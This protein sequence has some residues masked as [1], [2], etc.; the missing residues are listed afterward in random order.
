MAKILLG[1]MG[2]GKTTVAKHLE[3]RV[4][5]MD[6]LIEEK[7]GMSIAEYF[8]EQGEEAFRK[9]ESEILEELMKLKED[10]IISTGG[11]VVLSEKNRKLL[12]RNRH[13][14][15]LLTSSFDVAYRRIQA[16]ETAKRPLFLTK[17]KEEFEDLFYSR[18]ALYQD[19]ADL[20]INTDHRT[21]EE[22]ARLITCM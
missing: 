6:T 12:R 19:L 4:L 13:H 9:I 14:N 16:D 20:I 18:M 11:G 3:G 22:I 17:S 7:I 2:T 5:D 10:T 15:V 1:F 8:E 21:P